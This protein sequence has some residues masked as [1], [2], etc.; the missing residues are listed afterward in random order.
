MRQHFHRSAIEQLGQS[1]Q[2]APANSLFR[3]ILRVNP[4]GSIFCPDQPRS[5]PPNSKEIIDLESSSKKYGWTL[6][7]RTQKDGPA[8]RSVDASPATP[9]GDTVVA[10]L[11]GG[12]R[13]CTN[14]FVQWRRVSESRNGSDGTR[15]GTRTPTLLRSVGTEFKS[16]AGASCGIRACC[17][18]MLTL[19]H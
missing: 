17:P 18:W 12:R 13:S 1:V 6:S 5:D 4:C 7:Q 8:A 16:D 15:S 14:I 9:L 3:N 10:D 11:I 19:R 2:S